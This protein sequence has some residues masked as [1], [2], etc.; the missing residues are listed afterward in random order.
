[1]ERLKIDRDRS[2]QIVQEERNQERKEKYWSSP[3]SMKPLSMPRATP[4]EI[5]QKLFTEKKEKSYTEYASVSIK[6]IREPKAE[7]RK[8]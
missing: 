4:D 5:Q 6:V 2:I 7:E 3:L 1:M 8:I